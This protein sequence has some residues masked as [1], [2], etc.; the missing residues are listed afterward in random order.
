M[1]LKVIVNYC[2]LDLFMC[3]TIMCMTTYHM[4]VRE[5]A[6]VVTCLMV[7]GTQR[8]SSTR[9]SSAPNHCTDSAAPRVVHGSKFLFAY[10]LNLYFPESALCL[11]H[12]SCVG[13]L[14]CFIVHL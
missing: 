1:F 10:F 12:S 5:L 4:S 3:M 6:M 11:L 8:G 9:S 2:A 13:I 14:F 7:L